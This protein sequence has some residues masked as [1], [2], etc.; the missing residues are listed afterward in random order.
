MRI[1]RRL[2][3]ELEKS[4]YNVVR[5]IDIPMGVEL[6]HWNVD[7]IGKSDAV[8]VLGADESGSRV[9]QKCRLHNWPAFPLFR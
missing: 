9:P 2:A 1:W 4:Q 7:Q 3:K 8:V 5:D 6:H